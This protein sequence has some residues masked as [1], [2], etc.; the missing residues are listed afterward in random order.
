LLVTVQS[1]ATTEAMEP[2]TELGGDSEFT[3]SL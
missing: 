1:G 2:A 3:P